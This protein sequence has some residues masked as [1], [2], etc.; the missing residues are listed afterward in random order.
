MRHVFDFDFNI[1]FHKIMGYTIFY[2][3]VVHG[4]TWMT[5]FARFVSQTLSG[6]ACSLSIKVNK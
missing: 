6:S 3:G 5:S 4:I 1:N 2:A